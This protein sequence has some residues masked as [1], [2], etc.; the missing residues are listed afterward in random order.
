VFYDGF[1]AGAVFALIALL[2]SVT[3]LP[4]IPRTENSIAA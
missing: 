2:I 3:L 4:P 1:A